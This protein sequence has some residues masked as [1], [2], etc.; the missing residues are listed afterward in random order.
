MQIRDCI[1]ASLFRTT[2]RDLQG[3]EEEID[4]KWLF[5]GDYLECIHTEWLAG[6]SKKRRAADCG[7]MLIVL[8]E[9]LSPNQR[10]TKTAKSTR[11][12][13]TL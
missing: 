6:V 3:M 2:R 5:S 8:G 13:Q 10:A 7:G 12:G 11:T 4:I 1:F 9:C